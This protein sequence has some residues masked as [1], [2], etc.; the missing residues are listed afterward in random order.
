M[1]YRL[2]WRSILIRPEFLEKLC[3]SK[4]K[5]K[6]DFLLEYREKSIK[7]IRKGF[8]NACR[9]AEVSDEIISYDIR[10]LFCFSMLSQRASPNAVSRLM[11]HASTKMTLDRYG[12][13]MPGDEE[14]A[15]ELLPAIE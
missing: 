11:D 12:H 5:G 10:Y 14:R 2:I 7:S 8:R 1:V 13:V 9:R 4:A 6:N 15:A 3:N